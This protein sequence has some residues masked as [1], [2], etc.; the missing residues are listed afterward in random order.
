MPGVMSSP[1]VARCGGRLAMAALAAAT[2]AA[3]CASE[4]EAPV[5]PSPMPSGEAQRRIVQEM[6]AQGVEAIYQFPLV[7]TTPTRAFEEM[8]IQTFKVRDEP[9]EL[10]AFETFAVTDEEVRQVGSGLEGP[11][12]ESLTIADADGDAKP[13]LLWV[14]GGGRNFKTYGVGALDR[15]GFEPFDPM[16]PP[17]AL[18]QSRSSLRPLGPMGGVSTLPFFMRSSVV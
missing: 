11:G 18:I 15:P 10:Y 8:G 14:A 1:P 12:I 13:D 7:E 17:P 16:K 5:A 2:L 6:R 4:P 9:G 3:G